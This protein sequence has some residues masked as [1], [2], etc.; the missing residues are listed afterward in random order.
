[1]E[2]EDKEVNKDLKLLVKSSIV[3]FIA[4]FLSKVFTYAYRIVV[5][6]V[7]GPEVY[8]LLALSLMCVGWFIAFGGVGLNQGL[9]RFISFYR[10]KNEGKKISYLFKKSLIISIIGGIIAGTI[11]F[12]LSG[13]IANTIFK[14]ESL[15]IFLK[16]FSLTIPL[17][18][19]SAIF[20]SMLRAYE[21]INWFTFLTNIFRS[22]A[23]L[24]MLV[25]FILIGFGPKSVPYSYLAG[26]ILLLIAGFFVL[27]KVLLKKI[28]NSSVS[29]EDYSGVFRKVLSYSWPLIFFGLVISIFHWT[30]SLIIGIFRSV[31]EVGFYN[32]AVP[33]ALLLTL[34]KDLFT[35][36]FFPLVT[37]EY[38]RGRIKGVKK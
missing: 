25:L 30:D 16:I 6:R 12:L 33:I 2:M 21:K 20:L 29:Y 1:M 28:F 32:A 37:K 38:A 11:V 3:V 4:I 13:F 17:G 7:Y 15:E 35:Q 10:G 24:I 36:L 8:G 14:N 19:I 22:F 18:I 34:S 27:K 5:A 26:A 31:E 23:I 9:L